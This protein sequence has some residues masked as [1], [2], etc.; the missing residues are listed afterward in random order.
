MP[1]VAQTI[2]SYSLREAA[3]KVGVSH[4]TLWRDIQ[5]GKLPAIKRGKGYMIFSNDLLEYVLA[6]RGGKGIPEA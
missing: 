3:Q 5:D 4:V 1:A 2:T 6:H